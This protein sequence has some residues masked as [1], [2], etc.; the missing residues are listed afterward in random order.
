MKKIARRQTKHNQK[1]LFFQSL[2]FLVRSDSEMLSWSNSP[3]LVMLQFVD[4]N[5]LSRH[6]DKP[7][8]EG[9]TRHTPLH[10]LAD[11]ADP[12]DYATHGNQLILAKQL[13]EHGANVN[14][15]SIPHGRTPLHAACHWGNV[16]NLDYVEFLLEAG[17]DPNAQHHLGLTPLMCTTKFAPGA[18]KFLLNW[19][20]TDASITT[21]S[22]DAFL[23]LVRRTVTQLVDAIAHPDNPEKV[24]HRLL[25]Q[26][27]R[28]IEEMLVERGST[29]TGITS[30]E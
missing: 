30:F 24:Q 17:A 18:A 12:F 9:E 5:V 8:Q 25:L 1:L 4:P 2:H 16:T 28:G 19:P 11:L 26:Q 15:A 13:I 3:L 27:W 14:A 22:G 21:Q 29:D 6:D 10:E 23:A 7:L 20:T